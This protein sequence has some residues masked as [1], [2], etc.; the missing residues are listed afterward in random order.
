MPGAFFT[1]CR[2]Q[3]P[4][5]CGIYVVFASLIH[6]DRRI[7]REKCTIRQRYLLCYPQIFNNLSTLANELLIMGLAQI[8]HLVFV[9]CSTQSKIGIAEVSGGYA[10]KSSYPHLAHRSFVRIVG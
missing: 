2:P 10:V 7:R 3:E 6:K 5:D 8:W 4:S 9:P 1:G